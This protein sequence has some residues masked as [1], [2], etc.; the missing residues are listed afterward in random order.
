M[1]RPASAI[2]VL[3]IVSAACAPS[4]RTTTEYVYDATSVQQATFWSGLFWTAVVV[5]TAV[6]VVAWA[7][8]WGVREYMASR[9][10]IA[11]E[12]RLARERERIESDIA[13]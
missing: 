1:R 13:A 9:E 10:R 11:Y 6:C 4:V 7:I 5:C 2:A 12:E 3:A 8:A